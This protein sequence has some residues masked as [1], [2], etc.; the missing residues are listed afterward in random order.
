[1]AVRAEGWPQH[2]NINE[3]ILYPVLVDNKLLFSN[4]FAIEMAGEVYGLGPNLSFF[5]KVFYI[6]MSGVTIY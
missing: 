1:M 4:V 6:K 2:G 5:F 3:F